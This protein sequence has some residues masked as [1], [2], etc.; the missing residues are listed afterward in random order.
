MV[1]DGQGDFAYR[2][3]WGPE[4]LRALGPH[5]AVVIVVDVLRFTTAVTVAVERGACVYP[6][7]WEDGQ[8]SAYAEARGATLAGLREEGGWS[9]S[10]T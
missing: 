8:A 10:P 3:D 6:Y 5:C 7:P 1:D 2:F 9:L 4:G